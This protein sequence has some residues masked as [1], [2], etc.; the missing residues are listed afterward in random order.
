M[1]C[2]FE[3]AT[4]PLQFIGCFNLIK[5]NLKV[6]L[7]VLTEDRAGLLNQPVYCLRFQPIIGV[8]RCL[9]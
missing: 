1:P 5:V 2:R 4:F 8:V 3:E 7:K 9:K 6:L